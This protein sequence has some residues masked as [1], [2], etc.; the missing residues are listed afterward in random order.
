M[1][2]PL[3]DCLAGTEALSELFSDPSILRAMLD[4]E[5]AL[6]RAEARAG[7]IPQAA[8]DAIAAAADPAAFDL[9]A[10]SHDALRAGTPGIPLV[11]RLTELVRARDAAAA[12][13]VH[14]GATSQDISDTALILLLTRAE[15]FIEADLKSAE[16]SLRAFSEQH[17][18]T[19][20]LGRT[21]LQAAPPITLGLKAAGWLAAIRRGRER[22]SA[23]FQ[24]AKLLQFGGAVGTLSVLGN[25]GLEVAEQLARELKLNCPDAPWHTHRDRLAAFACACGMVTGSLGKIGRDVSL[26][27]Q[28]EVAEAAEHDSPGRGGS[29]TMPHKRNPIGCAVAIAASYRVPGLV[30]S[31]LSSMVQEHQRSVGGIQAEWS[32]LA[33]IVQSTGLAAA[34]VA[35]IAAG[36][37]IDSGRMAQNIAATHG[38]IFAEKAAMLLSAKVGRDAAHKVLDQ[39]S[40]QA[41]QQ[42]RP[43][44]EVLAEMPDVAKH[45]D[46]TALEQLNHPESY[47]GSAEIFRQR[48]S[49][50]S[51]SQTHSKHPEK[52]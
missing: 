43:L 20:M 52:D 39:A 1:P 34:S 40:R 49:Q 15:A 44:A 13:F 42:K 11:K 50:P 2:V 33:D 45:L 18:N 29:S 9:P 41:I 24:N 28:S 21:L 48:L 8:A 36:L 35:E 7:I 51:G 32:T 46:R 5:I 37:S 23:E 16:Q 47:L 12:A 3:I 4:F 10:L 17:K 31:Y 30:A 19:V 26:L 22:L 38:T 27:M 25:R 14:F 6:A